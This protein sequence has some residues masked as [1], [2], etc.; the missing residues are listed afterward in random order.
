MIQWAKYLYGYR[1]NL[2][3]A[4]NESISLRHQLA[5]SRKMGFTWT[6]LRYG[7]FL[8]PALSNPCE[9]GGL[10]ANGQLP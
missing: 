1:S 7:R 6:V 8:G 4:L 5:D 3:Q 2:D 9:G 10:A